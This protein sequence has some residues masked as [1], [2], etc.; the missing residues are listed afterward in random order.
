[1]VGKW[2]HNYLLPYFVSGEGW[3]WLCSVQVGFTCRCVVCIR[4]SNN[5]GIVSL[6]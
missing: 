3:R 4:F 1:M 2:F 6:N 5:C